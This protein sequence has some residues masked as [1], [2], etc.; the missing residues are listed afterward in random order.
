MGDVV[1]RCSEEV[2]RFVELVGMCGEEVG[3]IE[4]VVGRFVEVVRNS[5]EVVKGE[6]LV[7]L[8][9]WPLFSNFFNKTRIVP[10]SFWLSSVIF[11]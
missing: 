8:K 6:C 7:I 3:R 5:G 11:C 4:E 10:P 9:F 1:G 2:G